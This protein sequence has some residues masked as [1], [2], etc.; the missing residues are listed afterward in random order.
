MKYKRIRQITKA[1]K[2]K[3]LKN[4]QLWNLDATLARIIASG[5]YQFMKMER[6]TIPNCLTSDNKIDCEQEEELC[7][8]WDAVLNE[9]VWTFSEIADN[10]PNSPIDAWLDSHKETADKQIPEEIFENMK[11][12][13]ERIA[14]GKQLF[15][16]AFDDLWD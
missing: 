15:V 13:K 11:V 14:N 16:K 2:A 5:V 4:V 9:I 8:Q 10:Y 7:K 1:K 12:Y 3:K 6:H